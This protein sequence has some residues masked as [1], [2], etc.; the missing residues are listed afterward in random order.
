MRIWIQY[1]NTECVG[2]LPGDYD[3]SLDIEQFLIN[4]RTTGMELKGVNTAKSI[5][6]SITND[7]LI[8]IV[9]AGYKPRRYFAW[10]WFDIDRVEEVNGEYILF[11]ESGSVFDPAVELS[12]PAFK[13]LMKRCANFSLGLTDITDT[14]FAVELKRLTEAT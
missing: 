5:P 3:N 12:G 10:Y 1:H 13:L 2:R 4:Q 14:E 9:G 6:D 7:R 8:L 11:G